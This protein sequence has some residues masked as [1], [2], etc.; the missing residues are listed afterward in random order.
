MRNGNSPVPKVLQWIPN[1]INQLDDAQDLLYTALVIGKWV[2]PRVFLRMVPGLGWTLL[3]NDA[4]NVGTA[5]LGTALGGRSMKRGFMESMELL[6]TNRTRRLGRV[7]A[8][9]GKTPMVPFLLTAGQASTTLTGYGL[10]LGAAMG[11]VTD[12]IWGAIRAVQGESVVIKGPPPADPLGK[13]VRFLAQS[14]QQVEMKDII[15]P[16]DHELLIAANAVATQITQ[17]QTEPNILET[18]HDQLTN[19]R[20]PGFEPWNGASK[21]ALTELGIRPDSDPEHPIIPHYSINEDYPKF[22][23]IVNN[24]GTKIGEWHDA[25]KNVLKDS[26]TSIALQAAYNQTNLDNWRWIAGDPKNIKPTFEEWENAAAAA[27]EFSVFPAVEAAADE[28]K[29]W[30]DYATQLA[31]DSGFTRASFDSLKKAAV[32]VLGGYER[33]PYKTLELP[34]TMYD[35]PKIPSRVYATVLCSTQAPL[36]FYPTAFAAWS[37]I[38][39]YEAVY[40]GLEICYKNLKTGKLFYKDQIPS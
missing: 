21:Q 36:S 20:V 12:S 19:I 16:E 2:A 29:A 22:T 23:D 18:L 5:L 25:M 26:G 10:S 11:M 9:M 27:I 3:A 40:P 8:F 4:L 6:G 34:P 7:A 24:V 17:E 1:V 37:A 38:P 39:T 14:Q 32:V 33:R 35:W 30:L 15:S 13:A 31:R 28:V